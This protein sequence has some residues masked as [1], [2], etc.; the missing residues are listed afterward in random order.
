MTENTS[1]LKGCLNQI[2]DLIFGKRKG[3]LPG[4]FPYSVKERFASNAEISF[5][6][7]LKSV[8]ADKA[9]VLVK[10]NLADIFVVTNQE[11]RQKYR[12]HISQKHIDFLLC[13]PRSLRPLAAIELDD[14]SHQREDRQ[15][16]D[17]LVD[18]V[19]EAAGLPLIR[20]P[21]Q[22]SYETR[23]VSDMDRPLLDAPQR[24]PDSE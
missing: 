10:V 11:Q 5:Y 6:H 16:R 7:V 21:A 15:R 20:I 4:E 22:R 2:L 23:Q 18:H 17:V 24:K 13:D 12:G 8:V 19:F 1:D 9:T 3:A 14:S